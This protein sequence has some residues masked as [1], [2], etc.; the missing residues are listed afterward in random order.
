MIV[1]QIMPSRMITCLSVFGIIV[2]I[3]ALRV[4]IMKE[5]NEDYEAMCDLAE[6]VRCTHVLASR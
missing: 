6:H 2:S 4:E 3:Y 1:F 5:N